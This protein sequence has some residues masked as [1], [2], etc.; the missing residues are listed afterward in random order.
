MS[1]EEIRT[2]RNAKPFEPF[3]LV[4]NDGRAVH[5]EWPLGIACSPT[6]KFVAVYEKRAAETFR[7]AD[8]LELKV[9]PLPPHM[10]RFRHDQ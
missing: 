8:I 6:G 3:D 10:R 1:I 2:L 9:R 4:M 5:V 7:V